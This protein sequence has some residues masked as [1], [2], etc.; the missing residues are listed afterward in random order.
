MDTKRFAIFFTSYKLYTFQLNFSFI[1]LDFRE[2]LAIHGLAAGF[3]VSIP[4]FA[5]G[6]GLQFFLN[7][8]QLG[9]VALV[10]QLGHLRVGL[11]QGEQQCLLALKY[12]ELHETNFQKFWGES[13][14]RKGYIYIV[15]F[16]G[17]AKIKQ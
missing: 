17:Y 16:A 6:H 8:H 4:N 10:L 13:A 9:P 12:D 3:A 14:R 2:P 7:D 5:K 11:Q 15:D 1:L